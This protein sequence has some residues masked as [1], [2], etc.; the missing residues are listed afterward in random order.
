LLGLHLSG[1]ATTIGAI[2]FITTII[3]E[4]DE[5]IGWANLDIFS[6]NMLITSAIIIFAF[7]LLG[8]ALLMLLFDRNFGTTF[9]AVEGVVLSSGSTCCGSGATRRSTLSSCRRLG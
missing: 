8:T 5:S 7:P 9:F 3:Y 1:I 2:N 6:W 4:R